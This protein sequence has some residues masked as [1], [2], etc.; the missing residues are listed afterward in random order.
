MQP[1]S[2]ATFLWV[3]YAPVTVFYSLVAAKALHIFPIN[4]KS[5]ECLKSAIVKKRHGEELT[6]EEAEAVG[7]MI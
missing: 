7:K 2:V 5:H 6:V 3:V 1:D 4:R